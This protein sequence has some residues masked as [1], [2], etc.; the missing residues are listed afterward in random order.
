MTEAKKPTKKILLVNTG[1]CTLSNLKE[2]YRFIEVTS[3]SCATGRIP[4]N[5]KRWIFDKSV[6]KHLGRAPGMIFEVE[7]TDNS[8]ILSTADY[9]GL[10]PDKDQQARWEVEHRTLGQK[11]QLDARKKKD[12]RFSAFEE[13]LDTIRLAYRNAR[14]LQRS[15]ILA[16]VVKFITS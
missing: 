13:R 14:G 12:E 6:T 9:K 4:D 16:H 11:F 15:L 3:K 2:G 7:V 1:R 5:Q 10:W 8:A